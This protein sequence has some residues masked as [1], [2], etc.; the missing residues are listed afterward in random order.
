M[1][2]PLI[3]ELEV[4]IKNHEYGHTS[5]VDYYRDRI[6]YCLEAVG[7][8]VI[9]HT[10]H[11]LRLALTRKKF[12]SRAYGVYSDAAWYRDGFSNPTST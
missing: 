9:S 1:D 3:F 4:T 8:I 7:M 12:L 10:E 11:E 6:C 5:L 2:T